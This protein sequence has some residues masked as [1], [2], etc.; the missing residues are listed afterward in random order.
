MLRGAIRARGTIS[1]KGGL[2]MKGRLG[3]LMPRAN[4][5]RGKVLGALPRALPRIPAGGTPPET[6]A[7][8]PFTPIFQNAPKPSRVRGG[9]SFHN[10]KRFSSAAPTPRAL[11]RSGSVPKNL[12]REGKGGNCKCLHLGGTP[13][14]RPPVGRHRIVEPICV[15]HYGDISNARNM[16]TFLK[17]LDMRRLPPLQR[18]IVLYILATM[19]A[20]EALR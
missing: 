16:G 13:R 2:R 11:D 1:E 6:P 12:L 8:F 20:V 18:S 15:Q 7:P 9:K 3:C 14:S 17:A 10:Q 4:H 5:A 19:L